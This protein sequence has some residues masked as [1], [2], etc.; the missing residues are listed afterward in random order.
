MEKKLRQER[1]RKQTAKA[2]ENET[3]IEKEARQEKDRT[4]HKRARENASNGERSSKVPRADATSRHETQQ[5]TVTAAGSEQSGSSSY[6]PTI[7]TPKSQS[8]KYTQRQN[9][10]HQASVCVICDRLIKGTETIHM[11]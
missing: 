11:Q 10:K 6:G 2:R 3:V 1:D 9:Y 7:S 4:A 5:S 8:C